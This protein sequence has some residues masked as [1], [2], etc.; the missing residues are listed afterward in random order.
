MCAFR[1]RVHNGHGAGSIVRAV[2]RTAVVTDAYRHVVGVTVHQRQGVPFERE[3]RGVHRDGADEATTHALEAELVFVGV[4][5]REGADVLASAEG[6]GNAA[7]EVGVARGIDQLGG[8]AKRRSDLHTAGRAELSVH[9]GHT[10]TH[11]HVQQHVL[12]HRQG[13]QIAELERSA[14][15]R[16]CRTAARVVGQERAAGVTT[17]G[18]EDP[19]LVTASGVGHIVLRAYSGIHHC[20]D[21]AAG[22]QALIVAARSGHGIDADGQTEAGGRLAHRCE[23]ATVPRVVKDALPITIPKHIPA[24]YDAVAEAVQNAQLVAAGRKATRRAHRTVIRKTTTAAHR[25]QRGL[26]QHF[27]TGLFR[28]IIGL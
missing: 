12:G 6:A 21:Q 4:H 3:V 7:A 24:S 20:G 14:L 18:V 9:T 15:G 10:A 25:V 16:T 11:A 13:D 19:E 5:H 27:E 23:G 8:S 22:E 1:R 28:R 17:V 26:L 2:V